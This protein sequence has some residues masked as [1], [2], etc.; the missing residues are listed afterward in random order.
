MQDGGEEP[1]DV[2]FF[3]RELSL[4]LTLDWLHLRRHAVLSAVDLAM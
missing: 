2:R 4:D 1:A 3:G